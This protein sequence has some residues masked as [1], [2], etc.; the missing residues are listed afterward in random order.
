MKVHDK[1]MNTPFRIGGSDA[2]TIMEANKWSNPLELWQIKTKR[3]DKPDLSGK[4]S[5]QWGQKLEE[6]VIKEAL[7]KLGIDE[8]DPAKREVWLEQEYRVGYLD[9]QISEDHF[10]EAKTTSQYMEKDWE[11]GVPEY[12]LWQIMHYFALT[13]A[14]RATV[15]CLVGGQELYIHDVHRDEALIAALLDKEAEFYS[16]CLNDTEPPMA[17]PSEGAVLTLQADVE[18]LAMRYLDLSADS[19]AIE[20]EKDVI[21][22]A[23]QSL[24][25]KDNEQVGSNLRVTYKYNEMTKVDVD[26]MCAE[27]NIDVSKYQTKSGYYRLDVRKVK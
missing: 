22:K 4:S 10:I 1:P 5:I 19:K 25:G 24:V 12:Y 7:A 13:S 17:A 18:R 6:I 9:Y 16:Y 14:T 15:A 11:K 2:P 21:K 26:R 23:I 3:V 8:F 20:G 27:H